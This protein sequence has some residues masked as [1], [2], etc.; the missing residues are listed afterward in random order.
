MKIYIN[1]KEIEVQDNISV[2]ELLDMQQIAI[3]GTAIAIDNKLVPKNEWNDR[4]LTD[5][6]K[7][8]IIRATFGG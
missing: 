5:G 8:T 6:N 7:I 3:E 4:I 1:Q 2:K